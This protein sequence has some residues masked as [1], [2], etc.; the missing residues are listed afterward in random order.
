MEPCLDK[1]QRDHIFLILQVKETFPTTHAQKG[2][3]VTHIVVGDVNLPTGLTARIHLRDAHAQGRSL[4]KTKCGLRA[5]Q[6]KMTGQRKP[7]RNTPY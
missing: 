7:G 4:R 1:R 2:R 6:S 5:R 3:S